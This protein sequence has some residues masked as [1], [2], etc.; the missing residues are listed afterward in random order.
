MKEKQKMFGT[1]GMEEST[2]A[3]HLPGTCC[4]VTGCCRVLGGR[5]AGPTYSV[6]HWWQANE[7]AYH[8]ILRY[9]R[10]RTGDREAGMLC[11][12]I[13]FIEAAGHWPAG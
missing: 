6:P 12:V 3:G 7:N 8:G 5:R 10:K 9:T 2:A 11:G 4:G 13:I 1:D